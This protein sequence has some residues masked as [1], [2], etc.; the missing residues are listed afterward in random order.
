MFWNAFISVSFQCALE[1]FENFLLK[2]SRREGVYRKKTKPK[3]GISVAVWS[4]SI[5]S[6]RKI[7]HSYRGGHKSFFFLPQSRNFLITYW[8]KTGKTWHHSQCWSVF[9]CV[10]S[11]PV[12]THGVVMTFRIDLRFIADHFYHDSERVNLVLL[13]RAH[14]YCDNILITWCFLAVW[15]GV[16]SWPLTHFGKA[17]VQC[18]L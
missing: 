3:T 10:C 4:F 11:V 13:S 15:L 18:G 5:F 8:V 7:V 16:S 9:I 2:R 12:C 14:I 1:S 17:V 6:S